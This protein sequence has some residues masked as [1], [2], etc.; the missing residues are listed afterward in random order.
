MAYD[1][2]RRPGTWVSDQAA[3]KSALVWFLARCSLLVALAVAAAGV[4]VSSRA[5]TASSILLIALAFAVR[6]YGNREVDTA[7]NW[8]AGAQAEE[9]VDE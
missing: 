3:R 4:L 2:N 5:T 7:I 9:S 1:V 6:R 8:L